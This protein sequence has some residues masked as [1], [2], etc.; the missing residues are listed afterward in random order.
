MKALL[1]SS[2]PNR[3]CEGVECQGTNGLKKTGTLNRATLEKMGIAL[4]DT[5]KAI[6]ADPNSFAAAEE[7]T[8]PAKASLAATSSEKTSSGPKRP[9]P[10]R[11]NTG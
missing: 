3:I 10:F 4:T 9:A 1:F 6:P 8:K 11:A 5:Q 7:E 2:E